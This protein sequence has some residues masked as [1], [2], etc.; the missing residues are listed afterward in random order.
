MAGA[1]H[2]GAETFFED[3]TAAFA[4]AGQTQMAVTRPVPERLSLL[5]ALGVE[6]RSLPFG[7]ALDLITPWKLRGIAAVWKPD[8]ILGWMNRACTVMPSG[9]VAR[10]GRLG[11]YYAL[12]YYRRCDALICNTRDIRDYVVREGWPMD[13][14]HYVPNFCPLLSDAPLPRTSFDTPKDAAILLILARLEEVKGIDTAIRAL[15]HVPD[16]VLWIAGEGLAQ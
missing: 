16:A 5:Q 11:G 6:V 12:K 1:V 10:I 3:L 15:A 13:R 14:A 2:G 9:D 8:V 4:R 7:G